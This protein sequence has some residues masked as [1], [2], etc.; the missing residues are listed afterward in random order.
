MIGFKKLLL[1]SATTFFCLHPYAQKGK[2]AWGDL[3]KKTRLAPS[4]SQVLYGEGTDI[5][6]LGFKEQGK[7][8]TPVITR[9]DEKLDQQN[10]KELF[11]N[12]KEVNFHSFFNLK[13][14]LV[15]FTKQYDKDEKFTSFFATL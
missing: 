3:E 12:E 8:L 7:T 15:M 10:E 5:I 14:S 13:G 6:T 9:F 11:A 2:L 4:M 1:F